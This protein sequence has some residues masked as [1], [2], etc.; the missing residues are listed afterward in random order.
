[1]ARIYDN[2]GRS[3]EFTAKVWVIDHW[4]D[5]TQFLLA[6]MWRSW[7]WGKQAYHVDDLAV[8]LYWLSRRTENEEAETYIEGKG[9]VQL[10]W[11]LEYTRY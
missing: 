1:M 4:E 9:I 7:N 6:P 8:T 2:K 5:G 3:T 10:E 11:G